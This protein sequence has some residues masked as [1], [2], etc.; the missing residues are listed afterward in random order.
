MLQS[1]VAAYRREICDR[2]ED[3]KVSHRMI[4]NDDPTTFFLKI[5]DTLGIMSSK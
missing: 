1:T 3:N 5:A 2:I 4:D